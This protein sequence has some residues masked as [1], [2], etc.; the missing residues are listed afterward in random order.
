MILQS[1]KVKISLLLKLCLLIW[2]EKRYPKE[3]SLLYKRLRMISRRMVNTKPKKVRLL[4]SLDVILTWNMPGQSR[5]EVIKLQ[6]NVRVKNI[7]SV[8]TKLLSVGDSY[9]QIANQLN[10]MG[11]TTARGGK[12]HASTVSNAV[13]KIGEELCLN[14]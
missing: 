4:Q 1:Q 5:A 14:L 9:R 2:K 7:E 10:Q 12:W 6:A 3:L 8:V 11:A 13:K